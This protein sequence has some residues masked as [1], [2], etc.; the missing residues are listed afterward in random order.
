MVINI[1]SINHYKIL[2]RYTLYKINHDELKNYKHLRD[3]E[4]ID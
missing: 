2:F 1:I 4:I 3:S